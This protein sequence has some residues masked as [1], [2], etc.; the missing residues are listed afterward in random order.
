[1]SQSG[2][3]MSKLPMGG[4]A[5]AQGPP[6]DVIVGCLGTGTVVVQSPEVIVRPDV[7]VQLERALE[8]VAP[9]SGPMIDRFTAVIDLLTVVGQATVVRTKPGDRIFW[10]RRLARGGGGLSRFVA[11]RAPVDTSLITLRFE[12]A[13]DAL[14]L[15]EAYLGEPVPAEPFELMSPTPASVARCN[16]FWGRHAFTVAEP[17]FP[18]TIKRRRT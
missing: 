10:A 9:P 2:S 1:M 18:F 7:A 11:D 17:H 13:A 6:G 14:R 3:V 8:L 4:S 16:H 5:S 15:V 12:P